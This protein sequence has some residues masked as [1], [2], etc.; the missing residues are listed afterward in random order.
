MDLSSSVIPG[1]EITL[2]SSGN[3]FD[4]HDHHRRP[5]QYFVSDLHVC[6]HPL[7]AVASGLKAAKQKGIVLNVGDRPRIRPRTLHIFLSF[8]KRAEAS[9]RLAIALQCTAP[10]FRFERDFLTP[11]NYKLRD[12]ARYRRSRE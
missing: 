2:T 5:R 8:A 12:A 6:H 4:A 1:V 9:S 3:W 10:S 7:K 11:Q